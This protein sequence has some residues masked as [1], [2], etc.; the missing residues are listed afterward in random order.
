MNLQDRW[1]K[2]L[3]TTEIVR[4]RVQPL[5]TFEFTRLPYLFLAESP[6]DRAKTIVRWGEVTVERPSL[7]LP[8]LSP[9]FEG[10]DFGTP[11]DFLQNFLL[12][13]GVYFPSMKFQNQAR[14]QK[15]EDGKLGAMSTKYLRELQK[16]EN[17]HTGLIVGEEDSWPFAVLIFVAGQVARSAEGDLKRMMDD[18][19]WKSSLS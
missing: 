2:A 5:H 6:A 12:V 7:V 1:E 10:F 18:N 13:R 11:E 14:P 9:Q 16:S 4:P 3:K 8:T 15:V 17:V 19:R